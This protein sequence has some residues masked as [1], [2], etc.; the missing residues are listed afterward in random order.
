MPL[1][2]LNSKCFIFV[3]LIFI[4]CSIAAAAN[5]Y[6]FASSEL[7]DTVTVIPSKPSSDDS[8]NFSLFNSALCSCTE[9]FNK[10]VAISDSTITLFAE[11]DDK[12]C[13]LNRCLK[14]GSTTLFSCGP[15]RAGK[16][17]IFKSQDIYCPPGQPCPL[18]ATPDRKELVGDITV[19]APGLAR[20][21]EKEITRPKPSS[22]VLSYSSSEKMLTLRI[23]KAQFVMVT[24]YII[25]GE[26]T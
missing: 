4:A 3:L 24:A 11:Y 12:N 22:S 19:D 23:T 17:K 2:K 8:I 6:L 21:S 7:S 15:I 16:Y 13:N 9:Y 5:T 10:N 14:S 1:L 18:I 25:N 26:K 20:Q